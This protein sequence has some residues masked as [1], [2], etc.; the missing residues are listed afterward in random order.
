MVVWLGN[1]V[2]RSLHLHQLMPSLW[3]LSEAAV[4]ARVLTSTLHR[5]EDKGL[6]QVSNPWDF[7]NMYCGT[8][9][10]LMVKDQLVAFIFQT[11]LSWASIFVTCNNDKLQ[12]KTKL[13]NP[14]CKT[15]FLITRLNRH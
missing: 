5:G 12:K 14:K 1:W 7:K 8:S 4:K 3:P 15:N 10:P 13:N 2:G 6:T 9:Q 11:D